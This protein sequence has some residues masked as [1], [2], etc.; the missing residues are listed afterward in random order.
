MYG[1]RHSVDTIPKSL[2]QCETS[3]LFTRPLRVVYEHKY[4]QLL[5]FSGE[6]HVV[7]VQ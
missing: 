1:N 3:L 6:K 2:E 4:S 7:R 5:S